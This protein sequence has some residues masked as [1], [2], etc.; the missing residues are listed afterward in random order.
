MDRYLTIDHPRYTR[1]PRYSRLNEIDKSI[2]LSLAKLPFDVEPLMFIIYFFGHLFGT[3]LMV[4]WSYRLCFYFIQLSHIYFVMHLWYC[5]FC[6]IGAGKSFLCTPTFGVAIIVLISLAQEN[7][8]FY[9]QSETCACSNTF[10]LIRPH[11]IC[12]ASTISR[13]SS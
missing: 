11:T 1:F 7:L 8:H 9:L 3:P 10:S 5:S 2:S 6:R 4:T 12:Y 13:G